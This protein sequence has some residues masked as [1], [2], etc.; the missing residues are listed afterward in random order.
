[1]AFED[2]DVWKRSCRLS[3]TLYRELDT[4]KNWSYRDQITRAG[5]S[6]PSNIA[7]GCE[8]DSS[9]DTARFLNIA[10]GSCGEL[11]TQLYIGIEAGFIDRTHGLSWVK[12]AKEIAA[13]LGSLAKRY[14]GLEEN[15][16]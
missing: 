4:L 7:E 11:V 14:R 13:M 2:L 5:L 6:I 12:E 15:R 3:V 9:R 16:L 10:K 8:R 1:M